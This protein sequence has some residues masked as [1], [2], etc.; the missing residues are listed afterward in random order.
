MQEYNR[1]RVKELLV[2]HA[3]GGLDEV[4]ERELERWRRECLE[5]EAMFQ[6]LMS[7]REM[8]RATRRFVKSGEEEERA[9]RR[10]VER[11]IGRR[12]RRR[13]ATRARYA[14]VLVV[15]AGAGLAAWRLA[16]PVAGEMGEMTMAVIEPG[17]A[18]AELILPR[19]ERV[20]LGEERTDTLVE[21]VDLRGDTL[22]YRSVAD[23]A[24][25]MHTLRIPR[26][27]EYA[28]E[29]AD[30]T[31]V[32][33]NA[34]TELRYPS[35]F[36]GDER[37]VW[38]KG[39]AYFEVTREKSMPFVVET[40]EMDVRVLGTEFDVRAYEGEDRTLAT[41]VEGRVSVDAGGGRRE[42]KPGQQ[43]VFDRDKER[44]EVRMV[45]VEEYVG[46]KNGRLVFDNRPLEFILDE[47]GRWY[48]F[49]VF[50]A[51]EELKD[52]P[53]S[54]NIEKHDDFA[55]VL[56]LVERTGKVKFT[57]NGSTVVVQ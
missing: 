13:I 30:G 57:V 19:G 33:L 31:T 20:V 15:M 46:W 4:G 24:V 21:G 22:S 35:R 27:G 53:F 36:T 49:E 3:R 42:L 11:T 44:V 47:L 39:E 52:I 7:A 6:R 56:R 50:Y 32:H 18:R 29:L 1:E 17:K 37:R 48:S 38:L 16:G 40:G 9:W 34:E 25:E 10:L 12:R 8:E 45:D 51:R 28:L 55:K 43:A 2:E 26:G 54:L 41:L 23:E 14:A 5:H